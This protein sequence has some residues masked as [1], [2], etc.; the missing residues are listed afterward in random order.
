[1]S[2]MLSLL[3][4]QEFTLM[5]SL[6][7][8]DIELAKAA[9]RGGAQALKIHLNVHH[10]ASG[11][12]FGSFEQEKD[13]IAQIVAAAGDAP[14]GIVPGGSSFATEV[15]FEALKRLGVDFFDAYPTDAPAWTLS[16][17]HLGRMLAA[18]ET[19]TPA[20][21][22]GLV[23]MGL[24]MCEASIVNQSLY[25]TGLTAIDLANYHQLT[26]ELDCP[27]MVPSQKKLRP[28]DVGL[29][30]TAGL[31]GVLIGAVVTGHEPQ[32]LEAATRAFRTEIDRL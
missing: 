27:V 2:R 29:L 26:A 9:M 3:N 28:E 6:P 5:V 14:V 18:M 24:Q 8:N 19:T 31:K 11:T 30:R 7:R 13:N 15:E 10:H 1:M 4:K 12:N 21:I 20:Q 16:Q 23:E 32:S 25:G 22:Q 17:R